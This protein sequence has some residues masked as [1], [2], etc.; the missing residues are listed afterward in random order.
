MVLQ[1]N[2]NPRI[3]VSEELKMVSAFS[4]EGPGDTSRVRL[5]RQAG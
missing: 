5:R 2:W 3:K 4:L 1:T